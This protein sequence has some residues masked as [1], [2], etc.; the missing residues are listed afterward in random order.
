[1]HCGPSIL[2][3]C[4]TLVRPDRTDCGFTIGFP[5]GHCCYGLLLFC[6]AKEKAGRSTTHQTRPL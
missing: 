3:V 4:P 1:M 5:L 2:K 6:G